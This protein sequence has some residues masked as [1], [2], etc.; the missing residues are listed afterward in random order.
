V[1]AALRPLAARSAGRLL[2]VTYHRVLERA[3]PLREGEVDR[4][5]FLRQVRALASAMHVLPLDEAVVR[6]R[7][8]T[9]PACA[10]AV[11]F[12]DGYADNAEVAR[13][14]LERVGVPATF[15]VATSFVDGGTMWNDVVID[16]VER[17][18]R[19]TVDASELGLGHADLDGT[20]ARAAA[21]RRFLVA[22]KHRAPAQRAA[23]VARLSALLEV[24]APARLMMSR[25]QVVAL[26]AAGFGIGAHTRTHPILSSLGEAAAAD[27]IAGSRRDLEGWLG[28]RVTLF[29]YPNGRPGED[30][31][32]R[33]VGLVEQAGFEAAFS[34]RHGLADRDSPA[35]ALPRAPLW[36][37]TTP[38]LWMRLARTVAL[39]RI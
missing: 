36:D 38:K 14:I 18:R 19:R 37:H 21:V 32:E 24:D 5:T 1:R 13:P 3:D 28:R 4:D 15:F 12:D 29:A 34:T 7:A 9:L 16:A 20:A 26:A 10:A 11:T 35:Y 23:D 8:G 22:L 31:G 27:E 25:A 33:E 30:F 6:L 2:V 39:G 17:T